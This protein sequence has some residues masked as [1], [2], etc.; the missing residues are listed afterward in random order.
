MEILLKKY[1]WVV[2]LAAVGLCAGFAGRAAGH[3]IE[4]AYLVGDAGAATVHRAPPPPPLKMHGKDGEAITSRNIFCSGCAP[5]K[6]APTG[7]SQPVS[8]EWVKT[9][10]PLELVATLIPPLDDKWSM[11]IIRDMS[12]KE[13][14]PIMYN[15][16]AIIGSTGAEVVKVE[17]KRVYFTH[18]GRWEY[19]EME[20]G[21]APATN[22]QPRVAMAPGIDAPQGDI[23]SGVTCNGNACTVERQLVEKLLA[24]TAMLATAAR[25]VPSMK[26][27]KPNGFKLDAIRQNS[28]F[29]KLQFQNGD[30]ITAIN[31]SDMSTPDA[32]LALYTKL[33]NASHLSAQVERHGEKATLDYTI[34]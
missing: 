8:N 13:K 25:F 16:G 32:A 15:K 22:P 9:S 20:G 33:R 7:G 11:G 4:G 23:T 18:A 26:D 2:N 30:T 21:P 6:P 14:D 1:F 10:L 29:D 34:R 27:G 24:N 28:I 3:F 17:P 31:G 12:T 5:I 19:V